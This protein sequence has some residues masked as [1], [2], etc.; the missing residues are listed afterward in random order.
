MSLQG[1]E[2]PPLSFLLKKLGIRKRERR[3]VAALFISFIS[4]L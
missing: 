1:G 2:R 4:F 3:T